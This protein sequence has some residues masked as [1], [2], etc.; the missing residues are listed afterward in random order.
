MA[1]PRDGPEMTRRE[2]IGDF[3]VRACSR[4]SSD[5]LGVHFCANGAMMGW[6]GGGGL[7]RNATGMAV[8]REPLVDEIR[9]SKGTGAAG[10]K[11]RSSFF[12]P[13]DVVASGVKRQDTTFPRVGQI[14]ATVGWSLYPD[15]SVTVIEIH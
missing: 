4:P 8:G 3:F 9:G 13:A 1:G 12:G 5:L 15:S 14:E 10:W 6:E 2:L 11:P 7:E